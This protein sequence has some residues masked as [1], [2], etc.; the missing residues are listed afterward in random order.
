M[1]EIKLNQEMINALQN[2]KDA[3]SIMEFAKSKG[4][5]MGEEQATKIFAMMQNEEI[6]DEELELVSGG[7]DCD[8]F[9]RDKFI[10]D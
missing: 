9:L 4:I 6:S 10:K 5:E 7:G 2:C 3:N 8:T 1:S